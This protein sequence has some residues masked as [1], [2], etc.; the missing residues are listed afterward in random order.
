MAAQGGT[1]VA[2][3]DRDVTEAT[4]LLW[5]Q[6]QRQLSQQSADL[7]SLRTRALAMLSV[8]ALAAGLFG[9][10]VPLAHSSLGTAIAAVIA[11]GLFA[12]CVVLAVW[13]ATP[14]KHAWRFTFPLRVLVS[15]VGTGSALPMDVALSL[16]KYAEESRR[17][18]EDKLENLHRYFSA[19]CVLVGLQVLAWAIAVLVF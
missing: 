12:I 8:A 11:L 19:V 16:T 2:D 1:P 9:S 7:D 6:A 15:E 13:I 14:M 5:E 4:E 17:A 10:H 18:N 3:D